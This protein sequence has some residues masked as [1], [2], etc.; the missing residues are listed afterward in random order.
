M[1]SQTILA[2]DTALLSAIDNRENEPCLSPSSAVPISIMR[3]SVRTDRGSRSSP[4]GRRALDKVKSLAQHIAN[5]GYRVLIHD[6]SNCGIS[7][8][9]IGAENVGIRDLGG[10]PLRA[11]F[12][13][14]RVA[15][16]ARRRL[17]RLPAFPPVRAE[18][19]ASRTRAAAL[20]RH[21]RG[22]RCAA[23]HRKLLRTIYPRGAD[24]AAWLRSA[25]L[26]ISRSASRHGRQTVKP[27]WPWTRRHS[28]PPWSAGG[29]IPPGCRAPRSSGSA[30]KI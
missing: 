8:I 10:R 25:S 12:A 9:V 1:G 6:R 27:S 14:Q 20:A 16:G 29:A 18:I 2:Q 26:I 13:A 30:K 19:S 3:C 24:R 4:G 17:V 5:A 21:R 22:I 28:S 23:P 15:G 11:A 7:D